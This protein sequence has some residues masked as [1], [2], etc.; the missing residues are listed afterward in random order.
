MDIGIYA[1]QFAQYIFKDLPVKVTAVGNVN[2]DGVD[3]DA[4]IILEYAGKRKAV[5]NIDTKIMLQNGGN[6]YGTKGQASVST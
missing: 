1:L 5:L 4:T 3:Q 6:V 2:S